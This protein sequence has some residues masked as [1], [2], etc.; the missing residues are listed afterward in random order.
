LN[1]V[2]IHS[3]LITLGQF[4]KFAGIAQTG[5]EARRMLDDEVILVNDERDNRRGR[6]LFPG[7]VVAILGNEYRLTRGCE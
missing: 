4:L 2:E 1:Q 5:G 6:K 3:D 7:D